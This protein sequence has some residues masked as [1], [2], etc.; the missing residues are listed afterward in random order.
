MA[1]RCYE[2]CSSRLE[3]S[4][5]GALFMPRNNRNDDDDAFFLLRL[6]LGL[7]CNFLRLFMIK[8]K[9]LTRRKRHKTT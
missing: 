1:T 8:Q 5:L 9:D 3:N 4:P 2:S 7:D 6:R